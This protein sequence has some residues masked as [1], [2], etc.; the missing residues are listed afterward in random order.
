MLENVLDT[1][2]RTGISHGNL[3]VS[4]PSGR[5]ETY[6][7][8]SGALIAIR[9]TDPARLRAIALDPGLAV[10]E[11]Y[12]DGA[13]VI[14]HGDIYGLIAVA[15][16]NM[17][18]EVSTPGAWFQHLRRSV[19]LAPVA[20]AIGLKAARANV[21]HHYDL[22][23]RLYRLFLDDDM[24]YSCAWFER[25]DMTLDQAQ[26]AKKRLIA[27]KLL[28]RP[29]ARVL[30]IGCGWGGMALYLARCCDADVTGITLSRE[31][32]RIAEARAEAAGLSR[33][34]RFRLQDY[35]EVRETFDNIV[36]VGMFEHVGKR[37]FPVFFRTAARLLAPD[38]VMLLHSMTQPAPALYNQPF[39]EKYIF[40]GGYIPSVGEVVPAIERAGL[41]LRDVEILSLHYAE[42][43]K[44]W[45]ER[46]LARRDEVVALYDERFLRMWEFYLAGSESAFRHDHIHVSHFQLAREQQRVPL[47]RA[48]VAEAMER[49]RER[50]WQVPEYAALQAEPPAGVARLRRDAS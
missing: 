1:A 30:D 50:E 41:L 34:V 20:R 3:R 38:G 25:P 26:L 14:E 31:Q 4:F 9:I 48:Y 7:D 8:G 12:M 46:F 29:D 10:A 6:G 35:R 44:A 49:L 19:A 5:G 16:S 39:L 27:A 11:A 17:R 42:T 22:D 43:V 13:L 18:P 47:T 37:Q 28:V 40:P 36:S 2:L 33:R 45:R 21:A 32:L 23:E 15:K 24:Q